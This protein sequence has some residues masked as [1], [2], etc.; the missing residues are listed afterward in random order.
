MTLTDED[1]RTKPEE[2]PGRGSRM[3]KLRL[4]DGQQHVHAFEYRYIAGLADDT[5]AGTKLLVHT[6]TVRRGMLMLTPDCAA[7]AGGSAGTVA[8]S[9]PAPSQH[10]TMSQP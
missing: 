4:T 7:V 1:R 10:P 5:P 3:L 8:P 9:Q 6:V 2:R